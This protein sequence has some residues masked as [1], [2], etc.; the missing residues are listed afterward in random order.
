MDAKHLFQTL[1]IAALVDGAL[2]VEEKLLLDRHAGAL[3]LLPSEAQEIID[4][5]ASGKAT[6]IDKPE[7]PEARLSLFKAVVQIVRA[8]RKLT[9]TEQ[10]LVKRI[11]NAFDIPEETVEHALR[12]R[13]IP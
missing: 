8:D 4:A 3:K 9:K 10:K 2:G 11:G 1:A 13:P 12:G 6:G 7:K 5:V